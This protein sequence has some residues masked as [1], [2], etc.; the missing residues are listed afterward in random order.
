[1]AKRKQME[2]EKEM[3]RHNLVNQNRLYQVKYENKLQFI[4]S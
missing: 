4:A 2:L 3:E 1:M